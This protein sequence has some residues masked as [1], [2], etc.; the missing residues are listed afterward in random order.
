[1][2]DPR[3]T[4]EQAAT[5]PSKAQAML[6][7]FARLVVVFLLVDALDY[8]GSGYYDFLR[9]A[10]CA[11][12]VA[13]W[14]YSDKIGKPKWRVPYL[15]LAILF[16]PFLPIRLSKDIWATID[17]LSALFLF[18]SLFFVFKSRNTSVQDPGRNA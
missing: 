15:V 14:Y 16:N 9:L 1:M 2:S 13:G 8:H 17:L 12:C 5:A 3:L 4:K 7:L 10:V 11:V 18:I 6:F